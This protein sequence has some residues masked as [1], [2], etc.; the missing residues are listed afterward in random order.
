MR[1]N[2][3]LRTLVF[4]ARNARLWKQ[5]YQEVEVLGLATIHPGHRRN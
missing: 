5:R 3:R 2:L 1:Y 4:G